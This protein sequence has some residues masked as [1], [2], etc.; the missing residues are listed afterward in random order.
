[1]GLGWGI[2]ETIFGLEYGHG[3]DIDGFSSWISRFP[4]QKAMI[5]ILSNLDGFDVITL[6]DRIAN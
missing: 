4:K 5:V 3:G 6:K 1:M 2:K